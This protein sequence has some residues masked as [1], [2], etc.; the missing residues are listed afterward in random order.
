CIALLA[1][2]LVERAQGSLYAQHDDQPFNL[3][4]T[5]IM[6]M[7]PNV[8]AGLGPVGRLNA[9][10]LTE[11][12]DKRFGFNNVTRFDIERQIHE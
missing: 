6:Q 1:F 2:L 7:I 11:S 8:T 5:A 3:A 12:I 10:S 4:P 9:C